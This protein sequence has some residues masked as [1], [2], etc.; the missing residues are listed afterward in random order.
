MKMMESCILFYVKENTASNII[1]M[2]L[3]IEPHGSPK[4]IF[5]ANFHH[6]ALVYQQI[7]PIFSTWLIK[8]IKGKFV[9]KQEPSLDTLI[10]SH[11]QCL[12]AEAKSKKTIDW[13]SSNLKRFARYV[14]VTNPEYL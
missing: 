11:A 9:G 10:E 2:V 1:D 12:Q 7:T 5:V 3:S 8:K 14:R 4:A 6:P 13:Y